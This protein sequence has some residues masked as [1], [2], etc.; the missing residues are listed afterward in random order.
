MDWCDHGVEEEEGGG[1]G[2]GRGEEDWWVLPD[3]FWLKKV[4]VVTGG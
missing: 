2:G 1:G 3:M 4:T